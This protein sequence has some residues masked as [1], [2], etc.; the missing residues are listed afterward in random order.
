MHTHSLFHRLVPIAGLACLL[1]WAAAPARAQDA[2]STVSIEGTDASALAGPQA[3]RPKIGLALGGGSAR[4]MAHIGVLQW[5]EEHR[6]PVD[7]IAGTS[8]GGLVAGGY[9]TGMSS[10]E[11]RALMKDVDWD[12]MFIAD[13]PFKYKTFRRKE[14]KRDYPSQLEFGLK[15]GFTLP[16]GLNPGQ[17]IALLFDRITLP[18][19]GLRSFDDLPTPYRC[20]ATDLKTAEPVVLGQ[21]SL[22]AAMRATMA[23]PGVFTP[24]EYGDWLLVDGGVLNNVPANVVRQMGADIVIAVNVAADVETDEK[25]RQSLFALLGKTIDT[26]MTTG[27]RE[28][29]KS[30][31]LIVDPDL[32]G[33]TSMDWRRSDDLADRGYKGTEALADKLRGLAVS[34]AE[35]QQFLDARAAKRRTVMPTPT[36]VDV[37]GVP[38]REKDYIERALRKNLGQPLD[39]KRVARDILEVTGTDRYEYLTYHAVERD[40]QMGL[41]VFARPKDYGPPFLNLGLELSNVDSS[42]FA[43]NLA[44][45][46]TA[47]DWFGVG[48]EV[49]L[50]GIL[51]T[52]QQALAEIYKPFGNS[53]IFVA[54]RGYFYRYPRNRYEDDQLVAEYRIKEVGGAFDVGYATRSRAEF[55]LGVALEDFRGRIRVGAPELPEASGSQN[56]AQAS[57]VWDGQT[58]PVVP[59]RGLYQTA[60]VRYFFSAPEAEVPAGLP[61]VESIQEYWQAEVMGNW[62]TR[63]HHGRDRIFARYG[64]GTSFGDTPLVNNF[65]LGGP[66]LLGAFNNRELTGP[67]YLLG[68]VGYLKGVGRLPDVL[69]GNLFLGGWF[70]QGTTFDH[71]DSAKYRSSVSFGAIA[72][73]LFGPVFGGASF[74]FDGRFRLYVAI[75]PLFSQRQAGR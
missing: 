41:E 43:V 23:I 54:P 14:D 18:Y 75:G 11:L 37:N 26:M 60:I 17:Q 35:Y 48:S 58:S 70:E 68:T 51:G 62:F 4:G 20:V 32:T 15:D 45:R 52:T 67:N 69:G 38:E 2:A 12:M 1:G 56:Y 71:W 66:F 10:Q 53:G 39:H 8:M 44:G 31:D 22:P 42:S 30:A 50:N 5:F 74:D 64:A 36:F 7:Y 27:T 40:G 57:F 73:T 21:G 55:R 13:S 3:G 63:A 65:G 25:A 34:E 46:V 47:Y 72:E 9:A 59:T 33:L 19:Y 24:V 28:A 6:I 49:R 16:G 61:P 29:L